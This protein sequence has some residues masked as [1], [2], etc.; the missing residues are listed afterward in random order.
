MM[1]KNFHRRE[2]VYS[3]IRQSLLEGPKSFTALWK[4]AGGSR[5]TLSNCLKGLC[6]GGIVRRSNITRD[7]ELTTVGWVNVER[8]RTPSS[9]CCKRQ[10]EQGNITVQEDCSAFFYPRAG[11]IRIDES[12]PNLEAAMAALMNPVYLSLR[13]S[14][15]I[16]FEIEITLKAKGTIE[17]A[18]TERER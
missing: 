16:S 15:K 10:F 3:A 18:M 2:K 8:I 5:S 12:K 14:G 4:S 7:Y 11:L 1:T 17:V 9:A 13:K 6:E